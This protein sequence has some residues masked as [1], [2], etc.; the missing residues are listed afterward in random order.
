MKIIESKLL[1][2]VENILNEMEVEDGKDLDGVPWPC[3]VGPKMP[4]F[5][6]IVKRNPRR[7]DIDASLASLRR[8][9]VSI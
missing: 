2:F 5:E 1:T 3:Q 4:D 9:L 8:E 7:A 6:S